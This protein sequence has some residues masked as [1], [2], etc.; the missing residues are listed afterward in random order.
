M[1]A[2]NNND[3]PNE[4]RVGRSIGHLT[5]QCL[6]EKETLHFVIKAVKRI[7]LQHTKRLVTSPLKAHNYSFHVEIHNG[8]ETELLDGSDVYCSLVC[9][10]A[11]YSNPIK[12][13][14]IAKLGSLQK[15]K[16][17]HTFREKGLNGG[18]HYEM[19]YGDILSFLRGHVDLVI[20]VDI[21]VYLEKKRIWYPK[22]KLNLKNNVIPGSELLNSP[23]SADIAFS[24]G[25]PSTKFHAHKC[26]LMLRAPTLYELIKDVPSGGGV[27]IA[28]VMEIVFK[29]VLAHIY[30]GVCPNFDDEEVDIE[31]AKNLLMGA[32]RYGLTF[33]KLHTESR[34]V[35]KLLTPNTTA[36][37][38]L[39]A[40]AYTC[41]LLKE[42]CMNEYKEN[43]EE[44]T[45]SP[46]WS[47]LTESKDLLDELVSFCSTD[48]SLRRLR[49][50]DDYGNMPVW[51]LRDELQDSD[52][53]LDG[54]REMLVQRLKVHNANT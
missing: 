15:K 44:V 24:V 54:S 9:N 49:R 39:F 52:L 36:G 5:K 45:A 25:D 4:K 13:K 48:G 7:L 32:D 38:F 6:S 47:T 43:I 22:Q 27:H 12:V 29:V 31:F 21:Q 37:L 10:D 20:D 18:I 42:A 3:G 51:M 34:I 40:D 35:S 19:F 11:S 1:F 28:N 16:F 41:P 17:N 33:L 26:I 50:L 8:Y 2:L 53:D 46:C 23:I 30:T 14:Q